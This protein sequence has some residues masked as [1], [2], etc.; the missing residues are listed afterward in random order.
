MTF[1][2]QPRVFI[3]GGASGLGRALALEFA[4]RHAR[5][6]LGDIHLERAEETRSRVTKAGG[7]AEVLR[8]DV[9]R[10][11]DLQA[12]ARRMGEL[13]GGVD[14]LVNNAGV[15]VSG[16]VGDV[17]LADW[18]WIVRVNLFG[19]IHGCHAFVPLL[20]ANGRGWILNVAS[21]AGIANSPE[22]APY[23]VTKAGV[24]SLSE[25]LDGELGAHNVCVSVLCPSFFKTNLLETMRA[26]SPEQVALAHT[27]FRK[28]TVS[29]EAVAERAVLGLEHGRRLILPHPDAR[30]LWRLKRLAPG[31][32]QRGV[33]RFFPRIVKSLGASP[34]LK[35]G[36]PG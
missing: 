15:A 7:L 16:P 13:W 31:L 33:R 23:N 6:L 4:K 18:E 28:A 2:A 36:T 19:V 24:I 22:M 3:T 21:L 12:A 20:K 35:P 30:W 26:Q 5:V 32:Y 17:P 25:T 1:P 8:C 29:A 11:E 34:A 10:A 9:T 14:V 27:M